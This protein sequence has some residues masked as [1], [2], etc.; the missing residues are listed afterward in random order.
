MRSE[1]LLAALVLAACSGAVPTPHDAGIDAPALHDAW[2][3]DTNAADSGACS[4]TPSG[5][6]VQAILSPSCAQAAC[7]SRFDPESA[8]GLIFDR[9]DPRSVTV[10]VSSSYAGIYY[11]I[12]GD[13]GHSF[14][15][16]KVTNDLPSD[17]SEGAPMPLGDPAHWVELPA[18][19]LETLRCWIAGGAP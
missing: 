17:G 13:V 18:D 7:H 11:V 15:W 6:D 8:G 10:G 3:D 14:L 4:A 12:P 9:G 2:F 19:Q 16:R 5:A 1:V